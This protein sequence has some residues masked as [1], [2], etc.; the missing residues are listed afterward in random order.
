MALKIKLARGGAR[1]NPHFS[2]VIGEARSKRDG[3]FIEKVGH[4]HPTMK[5]DN[6]ER[7]VINPERIKY[8]VSV[9]ALPTQKV[10][11]IVSLKGDGLLSCYIATPV[12]TKF[13]GVS[14][15][16]AKQMKKDEL[17]QIEEAKK[18]KAAALKA[19]Q[20]EKKDTEQAAAN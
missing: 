14:K 8:W 18:A 19:A 12:K 6:P 4:Y 10:A 7:I 11:R 16:D 17:K 13:H 9:G 3:K 1:N 15:K 20:E 5:K 2:I